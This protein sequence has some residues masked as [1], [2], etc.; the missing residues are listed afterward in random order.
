[1]SRGKFGRVSLHNKM[2]QKPKKQKKKECHWA[3]LYQ[4]SIILVNGVILIMLVLL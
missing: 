3:L 2:K 1:M 4:E